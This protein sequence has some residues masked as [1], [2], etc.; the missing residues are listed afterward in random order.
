MDQYD[1]VDVQS[2][3]NFIYK[4]VEASGHSNVIDFNGAAGVLRKKVFIESMRTPANELK[5]D[6]TPELRQD[7][8]VDLVV[9]IMH[10]IRDYGFWTQ[11]LGQCIEQE[12]SPKGI[13]VATISSS[14]GYFPMLG[15]LLQRERQTHVRWFMDQYTGG[16]LP[17]SL[18]PSLGLSDTAT[19]RTSS[20]RDVAIR[21]IRV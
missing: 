13:R 14:Y 5:C 15:F 3:S 21:T 4:T 16:A 8:D 10:G 11:R 20:E 12:A 2:G 9:F 18:G 6:E 7:P 19:A 17:R 1:N